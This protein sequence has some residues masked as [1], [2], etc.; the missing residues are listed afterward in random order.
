MSLELLDF[1][2]SLRTLFRYFFIKVHITFTCLECLKCIS[3][4]KNVV[5]SGVE[6]LHFSRLCYLGAGR[7]RERIV[8]FSPNLAG[9]CIFACRMQW[10]SF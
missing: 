5:K 7:S 3:L 6:K 10:R 2:F 9:V 4:F 8:Q 1:N